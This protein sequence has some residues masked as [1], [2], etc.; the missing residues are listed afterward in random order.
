M[1]AQ[2]SDEV[3]W[4]GK[5]YSLIGTSGSDLFNPEDFGMVPVMIHTA[6]YR[7]FYAAYNISE[8]FLYL[9]NLTIKDQNDHY[10]DIGGVKPIHRADE[11][12]EEKI[13][14]CAESGIV[15]HLFDYQP[16]ATEYR[17]L[18]YKVPFT[19]EIRI[20]KD[21][22]QKEYVHMGFQK[23][24]AFKTVLDIKLDAGTVVEIQDRSDEAKNIR[25][26]FK[27]RSKEEQGE[28]II[29]EAFNTDMELK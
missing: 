4:D 28:H 21:F 14:T 17:K 23:A 27:K 8:G 5:S 15:L 19:G 20:A 1:T 7:G 25:G 11:P 26:S 6:C 13:T 22:I 2:I 9:Q 29:L 24:S 16:G 12:V 18:S 3:L 10:P